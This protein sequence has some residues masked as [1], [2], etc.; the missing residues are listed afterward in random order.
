MAPRS[1]KKK[2]KHSAVCLTDGNKNL[3]PISF[4]ADDDEAQ[5]RETLQRSI[6]EEHTPHM[7]YFEGTGL[8]G[9]ELQQQV[10]EE[11]TR[12]KEETEV[13]RAKSEGTSVQGVGTSARI[14]RASRSQVVPSTLQ[15]KQ[16]LRGLS[17]ITKDKR[18]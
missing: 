3:I 6:V 18:R 1:K 9:F 17:K 8:F 16:S 10:L 5:L 4:T 15:S 2:L 7:P 14:V 13:S 11:A 12:Q